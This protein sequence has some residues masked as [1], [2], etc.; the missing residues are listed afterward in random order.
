MNTF[1]L[2]YF[3]DKVDVLCLI[4]SLLWSLFEEELCSL[5]DDMILCSLFD[6]IKSCFFNI[7][8]GIKVASTRNLHS[9][10]STTFFTC[11]SFGELLCP[12]DENLNYL[13]F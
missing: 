5:D 13:Q 10:T 2:R 7:D 4:T 11:F 12:L 8:L 6:N 1:T 9:V 3:D